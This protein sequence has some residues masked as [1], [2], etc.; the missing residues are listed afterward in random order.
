MYQH[1]GELCIPPSLASDSQ[2]KEIARVWAG[3]DAQHVSMRTATWKDPAAWGI[4]LV[5]LANHIAN[6]YEQSEGL[7][8]AIVLARIKQGFDAEWLAPT[9]RPRGT[10][11]P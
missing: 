10:A 8:R 4:I 1:P 3:R 9:D 5:D 7:E 11:T 6:A 2:A